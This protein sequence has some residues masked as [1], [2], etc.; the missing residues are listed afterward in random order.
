MSD[1]TN[2]SQMNFT[3]LE[4]FFSNNKKTEKK[5]QKEPVKKTSLITITG[6][7]PAL[8]LRYSVLVSED[9]YSINFI[10]IISVNYSTFLETTD[11]YKHWVIT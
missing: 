7:S 3:E 5:E 1:S 2:A 10:N 6:K 11:Q 8:G 4:A 9:M